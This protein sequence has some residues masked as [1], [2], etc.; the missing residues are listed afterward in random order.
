MLR[1]R[2]KFPEKKK[3]P[4]FLTLS[5]FL[6]NPSGKGSGMVASRE[7]IVKS[8]TEKYYKLLKKSDGK[9]PHTIYKAGENY[10]FHFKI[11]SETYDKLYYDTVLEFSPVDDQSKK[12][13]KI[14]NYQI[15]FFSNSPAFVFT[16]AYVVYHSNMMVDRLMEKFANEAIN[17]A[18]TVRNP[19]EVLGFE[20]SCYWAAMFIKENDLNTKSIMDERLSSWNEGSFIKSIASDHDKLAEYQIYKRR[21]ASKKVREKKKEVKK[22]VAKNTIKKV[23]RKKR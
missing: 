12:D 16:Y 20:K 3:E 10:I 2:I 5:E 4:L 19:V 15:H 13:T 21:E 14:I 18:P 7:L 11:P 9:L 22:A 8:L 17:H 23:I 1:R 6:Q